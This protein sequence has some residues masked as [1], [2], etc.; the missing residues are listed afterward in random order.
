MY[1]Q[2]HVLD[3]SFWTNTGETAI[4]SAQGNY[5]TQTK[6]NG[7]GNDKTTTL[8]SA[9]FI[10][11]EFSATLRHVAYQTGFTGTLTTLG[12]MKIGAAK[13]TV[14]A[15]FTRAFPS[16]I[17]TV[18]L[19]FLKDGVQFAGH[20]LANYGTIDPVPNSVV[21][22]RIRLVVTLGA[23]DTVDAYVGSTLI[24]STTYTGSI[25]SVP[26][27]VQPSWRVQGAAPDFSQIV[28]VGQI[29]AVGSSGLPYSCAG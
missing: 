18:T 12:F 13:I 5:T 24:A 26:I 28:D 16:L 29:Y 22:A 27:V 1:D 21:E 7:T 3:T 6:P 4:V 23:N 10:C 2:T 19:A 25:G 15:Q 20:T 9:S 14:N 8:T 11:R 17:S